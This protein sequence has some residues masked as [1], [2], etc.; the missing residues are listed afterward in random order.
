M[1]PTKIAT[2]YGVT[3]TRRNNVW[4]ARLAGGVVVATGVNLT[5]LALRLAKVFG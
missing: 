3:I 1:T 5:V 4:T 2:E